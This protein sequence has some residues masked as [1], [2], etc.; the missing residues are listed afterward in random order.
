MRKI[1]FLTLFSILVSYNLKA[2]ET[3]TFEDFKKWFSGVPELNTNY[4]VTSYI[5]PEY[6]ISDF[7]GDNNLDLAVLIKNKLNNKKGFIIYHPNSQE[8]FIIGASVIYEEED[9][10]DDLDWVD[11]WV[12]NKEK[13]N[14]PGIQEGPNLKLE[15]DSIE[16]TKD[17]IGGG[18]IYWNG[19]KYKYFHQTC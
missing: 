8:Y 16:I 19:R 11:K 5:Q 12:I 14:E 1:V 9:G 3:N 13:N 2:K 18:L 6:L 4:E 7:N 15:F 10:W 17:E